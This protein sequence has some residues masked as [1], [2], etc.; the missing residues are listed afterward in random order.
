MA[1]QKTLGTREVSKVLGV[2]PVVLRRFLRTQET[3]RDGGYTR[4][5]WKQGDP[6]LKAIGSGL[7]EFLRKEGGKA[8]K[9]AKKAKGT[10]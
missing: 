2:N 5:E 6:E 3:Y 9:P 4:Y 8:S 10:R 1:E 7:K